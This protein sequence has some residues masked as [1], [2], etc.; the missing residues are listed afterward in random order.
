MQS[1]FCKLLSRVPV[2]DMSR[3]MAEGARIVDVRTRV[4]YY[5]GHVDGSI[6]IPEDELGRHRDELIKD[7][8]V[9]VC[10]TSLQRCGDAVRILNKMGFEAYNGGAWTYLQTLRR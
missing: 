8:P 7:K 1:F 10:S 6:N 4:E 3:L 9:V 2:M 5:G